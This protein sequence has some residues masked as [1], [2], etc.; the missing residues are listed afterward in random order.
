M[1]K[2][3]I[4]LQEFDINDSFILPIATASVLIYYPLDW[5]PIY[6]LPSSSFQDE[7]GNLIDL[8]CIQY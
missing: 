5:L 8:S 7:K 6:I 1:R 2:E 3:Y 4:W